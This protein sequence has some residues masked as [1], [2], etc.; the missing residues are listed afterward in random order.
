MQEY[1]VG[2]QNF[3]AARRWKRL[4][5]R[6]E[7]VNWSPRAR[8]LATTALAGFLAAFVAVPARADTFWTGA[9]SSDWFNA[10]NWTAG[11]PDANTGVGLSTTVP[12]YT[13][14]GAG[15]SGAAL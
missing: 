8:L 15:G 14:I 11:V 10:A 1:A 5:T 9:V 7:L 12:N 2:M 4:G 6:E 13:V 3:Q